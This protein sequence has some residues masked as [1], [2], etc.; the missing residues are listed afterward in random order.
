MANHSLNDLMKGRRLVT[1]SILLVMLFAILVLLFAFVV[2]I[3]RD[4]T[5]DGWLFVAVVFLAAL[6]AIVGTCVHARGL[7]HSRPVGVILTLL[8]VVPM[9]N[10][11]VLAVLVV[12]ANRALKAAGYK[13]TFPGRQQGQCPTVD[14]WAVNTWPGSGAVPPIAS[15]CSADQEDLRSASAKQVIAKFPQDPWHSAPESS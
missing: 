9:V 12:R 10:I 8:L 7:G 13:V 4:G 1:Y 2:P 3:S 11:L 15:N 5:I 6:G 14:S